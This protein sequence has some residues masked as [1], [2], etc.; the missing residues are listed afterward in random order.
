MGA[1]RH[2]TLVAAGSRGDV[3]PLVA[4]GAGLRR[5]GFGVR[6]AALDV[7]RRLVADRGLEFASLAGDPRDLV[8]RAGAE[9]V[10]TGRNIVGFLRRFRRV[11]DAVYL[12]LFRTLWE[13]TEGTDALGFG[14]LTIMAHP[15]AQ[16]RGAAR[17]AI[18]L[19]PF[20]R[21][22]YHPSLPVPQTWGRLGGLFNLATHHLAEQLYWW[23]VRPAVNRALREVL[24]HPPYPL[25]GPYGDIYADRRFPFVYGISPT[26]YRRP[27]DWPPWHM[28]TGFWYLEGEGRLPADVEEFLAAGPPPVYVG[29]GSM[30]HGDPTTV[31]EQVVEA[32]RRA[33]RRAIVQRGWTGLEPPD[34]PPEVLLV[35]EI[36][37]RALFPRVAVVVSH[38]GAG[39]VSEALRAGVPQVVVPHFADQPFWAERM[40]RLGV[41]PSPI[42]MRRL[43]A[44]RLARALHE[45]ATPGMR[46][47][48]AALGRVIAAEDGVGAAVAF[49]GRHLCGA[50]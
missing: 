41:A 33:G 49:L 43:D 6:V 44:A 8:E 18:P 34:V 47:A 25:R 26:V 22:R 42:P 21:T 31:A 1:A 37:H 12:E 38:A 15:I 9:W 17:F 14:G 35:D 28:L 5:A 2:V 13:A 40:H 4:L 20:T 7:F 16:R 3:Q 46:D 30:V 36:E 32:V 39:T 48:A 10:G 50:R 29:F 24:D 11:V 19:Q 27:P 23:T 45:T